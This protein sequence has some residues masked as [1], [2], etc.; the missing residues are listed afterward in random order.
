VKHTAEAARDKAVGNNIVL[1]VE[2]KAKGKQNDKTG[3]SRHGPAEWF[4][5][6]TLT[7]GWAQDIVYQV[8]VE[9]ALTAVYRVQLC[10]PA[11]PGDDFAAVCAEISAVAP[12]MRGDQGIK[13]QRSLVVRHGWL[14]ERFL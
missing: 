13:G 11:A 12:D 4:T 2:G 10:P 8:N 7:L 3:Q 14:V 9:G 5:K 1:G 6:E